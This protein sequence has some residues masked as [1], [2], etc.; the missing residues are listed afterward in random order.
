M[1]FKFSNKLELKAYFSPKKKKYCRVKKLASRNRAI[2][3]EE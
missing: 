1:S 2:L 3:V